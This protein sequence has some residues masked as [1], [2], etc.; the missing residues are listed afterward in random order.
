MQ[1]LLCKLHVAIKEK[2]KGKL[3]LVPLPL[4]NNAPA[5]RSFVGQTA[6]FECGFEEMC[7]K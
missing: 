6:A 7:H 4:H 5:H 3:T 1:P 2:H